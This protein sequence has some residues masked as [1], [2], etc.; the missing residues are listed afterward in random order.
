MIEARRNGPQKDRIDPGLL[1]AYEASYG[2]DK[3]KL[4][5]D[6]D[7]MIRGDKAFRER[8]TIEDAYAL[9]WAF[10][11]YLS[12]R[13]PNVFSRLVQKCADRAPLSAYSESQR[14]ADF[15]SV[16]GASP[17]AMAQRLSRFMEGL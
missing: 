9:S 12:E 4:E 17:Q 2:S 1:Y 13:E 14:M 6:V 8:T 5:A 15:L 10:T 3:A 16:A 7:K 11:F